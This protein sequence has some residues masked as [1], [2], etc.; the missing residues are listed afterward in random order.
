MNR[1]IRNLIVIAIIIVV[2]PFIM[3]V[4]ASAEPI[5][6][7]YAGI[8]Q[9][10]AIIAPFGFKPDSTP[11]CTDTPQGPA[12]PAIIQTWAGEAVFSFDKDGTGS[13]TSVI[14]FVTESFRGPSGIVPPSSGIQ[15]VSFKIHYTVTGEGKITITADPGTYTAEWISGPNAK[16]I[17]HMNGW[18][19][20]GIVA[21]GDKMIILTSSVADVVSFIAPVVDMPP[22]SQVVSNGTHVLIWQHD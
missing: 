3:A 11:S 6:G 20:K 9:G 8:G 7:Q 12:C 13:V 19:R 1:N 5:K 2:G 4:T 14:S 17:Y 15:K 10:M 21:P 22:T 18:A 16:K